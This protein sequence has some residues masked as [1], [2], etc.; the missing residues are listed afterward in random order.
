[1]LRKRKKRE[2]SLSKRWTGN[3]A[4]KMTMGLAVGET[5]EGVKKHSAQLCINSL[6]L[7]RFV[8]TRNRT[9]GYSRR[10]SIY[11]KF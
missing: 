7:S 8:E 1:M 2:L 3:I 9:I 4:I 5:D 11:Q 10:G 6:G